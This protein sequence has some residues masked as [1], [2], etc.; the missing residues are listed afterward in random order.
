MSS[1]LTTSSKTSYVSVAKAAKTEMALKGVPKIVGWVEPKLAEPG[2][3]GNL[4]AIPL[5]APLNPTS[6]EAMR[7]LAHVVEVTEHH[8]GV[9]IL[10][11]V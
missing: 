9:R 6:G 4:E 8:F 7:V 5:A 3:V 10:A 2:Y 1:D 11:V